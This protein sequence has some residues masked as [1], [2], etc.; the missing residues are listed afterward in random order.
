MDQIPFSLPAWEQTAHK[1]HLQ[2]YKRQYLPFLCFKNKRSCNLAQSERDLLTLDVKEP[3]RGD[4]LCS[5]WRCINTVSPAYLTIEVDRGPF[6]SSAIGECVL[7]MSSFNI[8]K[9]IN[10]SVHFTVTT[11]F[12]TLVAILSL[13]L[14]VINTKHKKKS[15]KIQP[16]SHPSL[17]ES[18]F[19]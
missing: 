4:W 5:E 7:Q 3:F 15:F 17:L 9:N 19:D 2:L 13:L 18:R 14:Y 6:L 16:V 10:I 8:Y 1:V 12:I 11:V